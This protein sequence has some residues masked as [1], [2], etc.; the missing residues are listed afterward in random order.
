MHDALQKALKKLRL[1]GLA[2]GG[3]RQV[4]LGRVQ[5]PPSISPGDNTHTD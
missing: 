3:T 5:L 4:P 1:S 2:H